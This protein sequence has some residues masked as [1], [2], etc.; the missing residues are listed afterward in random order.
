MSRPVSLCLAAMLAGVSGTS[1]HVYAV[2]PQNSAP[3]AAAAPVSPTPDAMLKR[4]CVSC[5]NERLQTG[6]LALDKVDL[7]R[8]HANGEMWE[9][10]IKK[11]RTASMPPQGRPRPD[12]ATY[13]AVSTWL[14]KQL[15]Q[16]AVKNPVPGPKPA[17][18]DRKSTRLN[19]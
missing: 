4:Y 18:Q 14:E 13:D 16:A 5:H 10:V 11:L 2:A 6:G 9:K 1:T 19:S 7:T 15:D 8:V 3:V 17:L 12:L